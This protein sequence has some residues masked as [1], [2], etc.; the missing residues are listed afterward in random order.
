MG[1]RQDRNVL[2]FMSQTLDIRSPTI[3]KLTDG[4]TFPAAEQHQGS[5]RAMASALSR[6][7]ARP[8]DWLVGGG[9]DGQSRARGWTGAL[10]HSGR[11]SPGHRVYA[12]TVSLCLASNFPISLAWG[13]KH[14]QIYNDGYWPYLRR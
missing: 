11:S 10:H 3:R 8:Q 2:R 9:V 7:D 5:D 1:D 6:G 13:P 4:Q 14:V 12:T